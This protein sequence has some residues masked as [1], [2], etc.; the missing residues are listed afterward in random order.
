MAKAIVAFCRGVG[1]SLVIH[2]ASV[3]RAVMVPLLNVTSFIMF[4]YSL[5]SMVRNDSSSMLNEGGFAWFL[6][7]STKDKTFILPLMA[8]SFS[9]MALELSFG[10]GQKTRLIVFIK[11]CL[12][13]VTILSI[14]LVVALPAGI[15]FYWIPS[16][17]FGMGQSALLRYQ[18]FLKLMR[19]P[20]SK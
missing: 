8:V 17:V 4:A 13:M 3:T 14:P 10:I 7:L 18:P 20:H 9:Y 5:R 6:D 2:S 15:F 12:Q 19:L 11:D 16:V 1:A